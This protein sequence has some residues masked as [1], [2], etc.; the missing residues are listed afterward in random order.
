MT[1]PH[2]STDRALRI[3]LAL[4][5]YPILRTRIR[6]RMRRELFDRGV[7]LPKDF[8][9]QVR[10]QAVR[11]QTREGLYD[12]FWEESEDVW[13]TRLTRVRSHLTDY[14]FAY[15]LQYELF[16]EI[17][18]GVLAERLQR[19]EQIEISFNPEL[20]PQ[21]M[22][23]EHAQAIENLPPDEFARY[24][25][26][27]NELI[28]VL[29]RRMISDQL[30]YVNIAKKWFKV[31]DLYEIQ[32]RKIGTGKVG[33]KAA[34][35]LLAARILSEVADE[36]IR[37]N[38]RIPESY[39]LGAD[40]MYAFMAIN[41]LVHWA[42][43]KYKTQDQI[44][45]DYER[46]QQE[47][48]DAIF[49]P[50]IVEKL[51]KMLDEVDGRPLIVRSSSLLEDNFGTS[52][53]GKYESVFVPNQ[54]TPDE[55]LIAIT[56]AITRVYASG[57]NPDALL[58]R[59]SMGLQD[60]DERLAVLI[61]VV[62]GER[63]GKYYFP[64]IAGVGFSRNLYRWS[65]EIRKEDGFLRMV[66]GLGTRAVDRV[67][68]DYPRMVALSHPELRPDSSTI[69]IRR[70]S[71]QYIDLINLE[72]NRFE[73][74]PI[75]EVLTSR[76]PP[77]RYL[78]ELDQGGY[79]IPI[80]SAILN[81]S[82]DHVV[83]TFQGAIQRTPLADRMKRILS[84]LEEN[85]HRPVDMEFAISLT[86]LQELQPNALITILQC[87]PQAH[88]DGGEGRLPEKINNEDVVFSTHRMVPQ[89]QVKDIRYVLF[90]SPEGYYSLPTQAA[91][92][93][94]GRA[95]GRLN[96]LLAEKTFICVGP[97]R[98]GTTNPDLGVYIGYADIYNTHS[99]V[100]LAG[101]GIGPAPEPSFGTHFFQDLVEAN[102]YPLAVFL[103]DENVV[104]NRTFFYETPNSL[105][106]IS[107]AENSLDGCLRLIE[108]SSFRADH[109]IDLIMDE[110]A[111]Q[112]VA[113]LQPDHRVTETVPLPPAE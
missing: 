13:E 108:V 27:L 76:Y 58:Y 31:A 112:A 12:P 55:N 39:F 48:Q 51:S 61:Q 6:A 74:L 64:Q 70:Y 79:L 113:L 20:A 90:V 8:E 77:L 87:R 38:I 110:Q 14:Y 94:V 1:L 88:S 37:Q 3:Y 60:Y 28:V 42:D 30:A 104:F 101:E 93:E 16:E 9:A 49:P 95:V 78:A 46:I 75:Q 111:G 54:G 17:V 35:M 26:R 83:L 102:I 81:G 4:A 72:E 69:S 23:F 107:P 36:D 56:N 99:L 44:R 22:L 45:M 71:Q 86:D 7:I 11:S 10:D 21:E 53:A 105:N 40:A 97:G 96:Q 47:Y 80:R 66:W 57:L 68:R 41:G 82:F 100:E 29:I 84:I 89:G 103:D 18:R 62:E 25:H 2:P 52:F 73:S 33:G 34:G 85:Y 32:R 59:R 65:P 50:D 92:S 109:H 5:Q 43:Q 24:E 15:N 19:T 106:K 63:C 91:R 98:W 67:G